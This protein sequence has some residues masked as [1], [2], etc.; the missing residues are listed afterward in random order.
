LCCVFQFFHL[1]PSTHLNSPFSTN[2]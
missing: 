2:H 1:F